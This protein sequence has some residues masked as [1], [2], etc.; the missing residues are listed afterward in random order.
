MADAVIISSDDLIE[1][2][3]ATQGLCYSD[4]YH[5]IDAKAVK[6]QMMDSL[7]AAVTANHHIVIDRTNL[8]RRVRAKLLERVPDHYQRIALVFEVPRAELNRRLAMRGE[9]K[10]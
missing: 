8:S 9:A 7:A 3:A 4:A 1:Q 2:W 5:K 6:Q 10:L